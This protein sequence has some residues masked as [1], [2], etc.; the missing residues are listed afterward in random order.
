MIKFLVKVFIHLFSFAIAGALLPIYLPYY[1]IKECVCGSKKSKMKSA[2][3]IRSMIY[4][5]S[6]T[7][8]EYELYCAKRLSKEG[9]RHV[10]VTKSSGDFG[11][12]VIGYDRKGKKVCF[13]CK[14][15]EKAVGVSAVQEVL[16]SMAYYD[17]DKG[18]VITTSTFTPAARKLA[19]SAKIQLI[20]HY[21]DKKIDKLKWIDSIEDYVTIME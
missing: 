16:A 1:I 14:K 20:E 13:Q 18:A 12:D 9:F 5:S 21:H 4:S 2:R 15:Y 11:A 3:H 10:V 8:R 19:K 6:M 17:A 7:G